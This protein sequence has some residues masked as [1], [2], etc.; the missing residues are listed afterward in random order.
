MVS[1]DSLLR[2]IIIL[3]NTTNFFSFATLKREN[4]AKF[5][6]LENSAFDKKSM[7][8]KKTRNAKSHL[9]V[10]LSNNTLYSEACQHSSGIIPM[11]LF[12]CTIERMI[13]IINSRNCCSFIFGER[14][15]ELNEFAKIQ[16]H[17]T[18]AWTRSV[19]AERERERVH[20]FR[21]L[22]H[23]WQWECTF[24]LQE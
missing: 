3:W 7:Q 12:I 16:F 4:N 13:N 20:F 2:I 5:V 22:C 18:W 15:R 1:T 23:L 14:E 11:I 17:W 19:C 10:W 8:W 6:S 21:E 9:N 24:S